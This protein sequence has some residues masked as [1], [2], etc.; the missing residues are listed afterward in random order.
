M[1]NLRKILRISDDVSHA[2]ASN[3]P[4]VALESTIYTHGALAQDLMLEKIVRE[5]G[6]VPAVIGILDGVPTVGLTPDEIDRMV[7]EGKPVKAS[8]RDIAFLAGR[9]SLS[10]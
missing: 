7:N 2:I 9:V 6:G 8:R 5:H 4:V 10:V 3:Q 1:G